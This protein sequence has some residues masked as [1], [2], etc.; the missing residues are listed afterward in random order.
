MV[1]GVNKTIIEINNTGSKYFDRVVLFVNPAYSAVPQSRLESKAA[2][3][4]RA[5][6]PFGERARA[7]NK[8]KKPKRARLLTGLLLLAVLAALVVFLI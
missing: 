4:I 2:A 8:R 6:E 7:K 5:A 1:K 3:I